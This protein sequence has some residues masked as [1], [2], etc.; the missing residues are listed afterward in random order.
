MPPPM[1]TDERIERLENG[2]SEI[3]ES[4]KA[5]IA[6]QGATQHTVSDLAAVIG[7]YTDAAESRMRRIEENLDGLIRAI[8]AEH[9]NGKN[10]R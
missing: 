7:S 6:L 8:T 2:W 5:L 9:S 10:A 1:T 3:Q 4:L